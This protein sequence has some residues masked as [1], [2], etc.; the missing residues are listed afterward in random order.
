MERYYL[1]LSKCIAAA[2]IIFLTF[3][4]AMFNVKKS[5]N[6]LKNLENISDIV[7]VLAP[8][9]LTYFTF[10]IMN[11]FVYTWVQDD[12]FLHLGSILRE[13][14][15]YLATNWIASIIVSFCAVGHVPLLFL[16]ASFRKGLST[17]AVMLILASCLFALVFTA[18]C[19]CLI[20]SLTE[21]L[22]DLANNSSK[23]FMWSL[24]YGWVCILQFLGSGNE[25][26]KNMETTSAEWVEK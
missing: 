3:V 2:L 25:T 11:G 8:L 9:L 17:K 14:S 21:G 6:T 12:T 16:S 10:A 18:L 24:F 15:S 13:C 20:P 19:C 23:P 1:G 22:I 26:V 5:R 7:L 4:T